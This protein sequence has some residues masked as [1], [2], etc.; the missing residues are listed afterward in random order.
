MQY[1][2]FIYPLTHLLT[3]SPTHPPTPSLL[4][5][6]THSLTHSLTDSLTHTAQ[7][8]LTHSLT[9]SLTDS[10]ESTERSWGDKINLHCGAAGGKDKFIKGWWNSN[11]PACKK[12]CEDN[13]ACQA[14]TIFNAA[15]GFCSL[16]STP[17]LST[18]SFGVSIRLKG[19]IYP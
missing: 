2:S 10:L 6:F 8:P 19:I 13:A 18:A 5:L 15:D 16:W 14:I 4:H 1:N 3:N 12:A 11:E 9:H 7:R 17:C